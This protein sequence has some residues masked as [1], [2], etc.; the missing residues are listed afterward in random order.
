MHTADRVA[1][2]MFTSVSFSVY[3]EQHHVIAQNEGDPCS[4]WT[5]I[6]LLLRVLI[7]GG[8]VF[9]LA[10]WLVSLLEQEKN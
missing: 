8:R 3:Q 9:W 4:L 1:Q 7:V 10:S 5:S 6:V 2:K